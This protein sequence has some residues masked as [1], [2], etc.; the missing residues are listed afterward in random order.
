LEELW[1]L[2]EGLIQEAYLTKADSGLDKVFV[3]HQVRRHCNTSTASTATKRIRAEILFA[4]KCSQYDVLI[5]EQRHWH[6]LEQ[7][8]V[9][10]KSLQEELLI[11]SQFGRRMY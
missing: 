1:I 2:A 8:P 4:L 6:L 10:L 11:I 5:N 7:K 9:T 3:S